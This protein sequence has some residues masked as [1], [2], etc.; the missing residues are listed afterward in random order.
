MLIPSIK[1]NTATFPKNI[2]SCCQWLSKVVLCRSQNIEKNSNTP[3]PHSSPE[4]SP[5]PAEM[6]TY[7][8]N[9]ISLPPDFHSESKTSEN[10]RVEKLSLSIP[11]ANMALEEVVVEK[12]SPSCSPQSTSSTDW[13]IVDLNSPTSNSQKT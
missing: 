10:S 4:L 1:I 11:L 5:L 8:P 9:K 3:T 2:Q 12:F 7:F 13:V 6:S